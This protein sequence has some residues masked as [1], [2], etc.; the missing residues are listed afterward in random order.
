MNSYVT[1]KMSDLSRLNKKIHLSDNFFKDIIEKFGMPTPS[2]GGAVFV[3]SGSL[4]LSGASTKITN[5]ATLPA[6][7]RFIVDLPSDF[8][9]PAGTGGG[10]FARE[11]ANLTITGGATVSYNRPDDCNSLIASICAP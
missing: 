3:E 7:Y 8:D 10:I 5:N 1:E 9:M 4:T 11:G 2:S 6:H